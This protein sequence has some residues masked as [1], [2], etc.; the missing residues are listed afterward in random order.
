MDVRLPDAVLALL[1]AVT[2]RFVLAASRLANAFSSASRRLAPTASRQNSTHAVH[3]KFA[4]PRSL[5]ARYWSAK[6]LAV[7]AFVC[8]RTSRRNVFAEMAHFVN[9][10]RTRSTNTP[11]ANR[12]ALTCADAMFFHLSHAVLLFG[13]L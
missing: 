8:N 1:A 12:C 10:T 4:R 13:T 6:L 7:P 11:W 3:A 2:T 9:T 5:L